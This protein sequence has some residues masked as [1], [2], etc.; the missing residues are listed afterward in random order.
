MPLLNTYCTMSFNP[1]AI[2]FVAEWASLA[3]QQQNTSVLAIQFLAELER[4]IFLISETTDEP[5]H[6]R[7]QE[8]MDSTLWSKFLNKKML[9]LH[10]VKD[11]FDK[12]QKLINRR[13]DETNWSIAHRA[14]RQSLLGCLNASE[15]FSEEISPKRHIPDL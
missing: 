1:I 15:V 14:L 4:T 6:V 5:D 9:Y 7:A 3:S 10:Q 2:L 12:M 13:I 11:E 8:L